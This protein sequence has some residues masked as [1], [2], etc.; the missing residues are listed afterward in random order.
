MIKLVG[1]SGSNGIVRPSTKQRLPHPFLINR[2]RYR[3]GYL[4]ISRLNANIDELSSKTSNRQQGGNAIVSAETGTHSGAKSPTR[5]TGE[6]P[7]AS[8]LRNLPIHRY[9]YLCM[10]KYSNEV[11]KAAHENASSS[12]EIIGISPLIS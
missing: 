3:T 12:H 5:G 2:Y 10:I 4:D 7:P 9:V 6:E 11:A 8:L 1:G